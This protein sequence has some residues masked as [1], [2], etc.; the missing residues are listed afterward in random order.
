MNVLK[1]VIDEIE[2][3]LKENCVDGKCIKAEDVCKELEIDVKEF[4]GLISAIIRL[5]M[6]PEYKN[7]LGP[8]RGIGRKD[9]PPQKAV[10]SS[11]PRVVEIPDYFLEE[12]KEVLEELVQPG[13]V[14]RDAILA[15]ME[16]TAKNAKSLISAAIKLPE[17]KD[18]YGMRVGK[19]GGVI[20]KDVSE[21][22]DLDTDLEDSIIGDESDVIVP[23][24]D[25]TQATL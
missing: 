16:T 5:D 3:I 23:A 4:R 14:T 1:P 11:E 17:F 22:K 9:S 12:L 18:K 24:K 10:R 20:L 13:P 15:E 8:G 19:G 7:Y 21:V 6:I 25:T 2:K